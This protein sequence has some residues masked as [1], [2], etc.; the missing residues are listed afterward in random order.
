MRLIECMATN[1]NGNQSATID[2]DKVV[3]IIKDTEGRAVLFFTGFRV[4]TDIPYEKAV[5]LWEN[6]KPE[7][8][9]TAKF[10]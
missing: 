8:G 6:Y 2:L 9:V 4:T 1:D 3:M 7:N 10:D 5:P